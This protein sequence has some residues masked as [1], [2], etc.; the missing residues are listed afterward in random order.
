M[1]SSLCLLQAV[2]T[3]DARRSPSGS[4]P[5]TLSTS[6]RRTPQKRLT[7]ERQSRARSDRLLLLKPGTSG[8]CAPLPHPLSAAR[9]G[10]SAPRPPPVPPFPDRGSP[11]A[12]PRPAVRDPRRLRGKEEEEEPG[13]ELCLCPD[14]PAGR[15]GTEPCGRWAL[16]SQSSFR[17]GRKVIFSYSEDV[18]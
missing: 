13:A 2:L 9:C 12:L 3:Q 8:R 18:I 17:A 14:R 11:A 15:G 6:P 5:G 4:C 7:R 10:P 16:C 1:K